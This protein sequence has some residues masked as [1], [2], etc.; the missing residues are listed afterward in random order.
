MH[1]PDAEH[2]HLAPTAAKL[3]NNEKKLREFKFD[4][5][6]KKVHRKT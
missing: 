2:V 4:Q 1:V 5:T 6:G 3:I